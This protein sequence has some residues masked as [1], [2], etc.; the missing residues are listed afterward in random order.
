MVVGQQRQQPVGSADGEIQGKLIQLFVDAESRHGL[1]SVVG[2]EASLGRGAYHRQ[3]KLE[4]R[5]QTDGQDGS[6]VLS[7]IA[8]QAGLYADDRSPALHIEVA[9][10]KDC[11]DGVGD[12]CRHTCTHG[13][14]SQHGRKNEN[15]VQKNIDH[16][17]QRHAQR[18]SRR[19]SLGADQIGQ[20]HIEDGEGSAEDDD[21]TGVAHG[22]ADGILLCAEQVQNRLSQ[23]PK[24]H[25]K[26]E[27]R[28]GTAPEGYGRDLPR[29]VCILF[30]QRTG[31]GAGAAY[32]EQV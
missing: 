31:K 15:R 7:C 3:R 13:A 24:H 22:D 11:A 17:A 10:E 12:G 20:E 19:I 5:G 30:S 28:A 4:R 2:D 26:Q 18:R 8:Q 32:A 21:P 9:K 27:R 29:A 6:D 23:K 25:G 16:A 14:E 1:G